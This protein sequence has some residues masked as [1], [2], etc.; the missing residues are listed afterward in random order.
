MGLLVAEWL[1]DGDLGLELRSPDPP[2]SLSPSLVNSVI[3]PL[4]K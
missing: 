1:A 3:S 2:G 4:S